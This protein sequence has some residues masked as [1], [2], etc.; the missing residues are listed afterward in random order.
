MS[1]SELFPQVEPGA[2]PLGTRVLIQLRTPKAKSAGGIL[3]TTDTKDT[4]KW[5][6]QVGR[7]VS[8]GPLAFRNRSTQEP[9]PEG[10]WVSVGD[11]VRVPKYGGDRW[12]VDIK[13]QDPALFVMFN[14][15][16]LIA[17]VVGDPL[18]MR[19]FV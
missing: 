6:T 3:L 18:Q 12:Q 7:V 11:F 5:N 9:W 13:D 4:E 1:D 10:S 14:D 2:I 8:I 16:E 15:H 19:A 17:K